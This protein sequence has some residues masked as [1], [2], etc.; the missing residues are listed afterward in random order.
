MAVKA[1][2]PPREEKQPSPHFLMKCQTSYEWKAIVSTLQNLTE[3]A[4]FDV[5]SSGVRFRAMDPSHIALIDLVWEAGGFEKF[6]FRGKAGEKD[7]FAVRIEDFA[8]IIKRADRNDSVTISRNGSSSSSSDALQIKLGEHRNFEFH[9]L[10]R[11]SASTPLPKLDLVSKFSISSAAFERVLDDISALTNH[12]RITAQPGGTLTFSGKGDAG[13]AKIVF[14]QGE[15]AK[16]DSPQESDSVY[17]LE[18]IQKV[19]KP[20][21]SSSGV[22]EFSFGSKMPLAASVNVGDTSK[23]KLK[24]TFILAPRTSD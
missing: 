20:A 14:A 22:V 15:L 7:R 4:S 17:S 8:K 24:L 11:D 23:S 21:S 1:E 3:E 5:D 12:V 2:D 19:L 9:L 16:F 10:E 6:E 13:S 18:Y